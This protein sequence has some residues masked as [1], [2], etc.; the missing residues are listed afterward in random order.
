V[1]HRAPAAAQASFELAARSSPMKGQVECGDGWGAR[2][3]GQRQLLC[4][5]DGLGHGPLAALA[6]RRAIEAFSSAQQEEAPA[7]IVQR[8]HEALKGT[9]G[10]VMAVL[11]ID[12]QQR[13]AVFCGI[14][15]ISAAVYQRSGE[16]HQHLL[17][18]E[19][20]VGYRMRAVRDE[21]IAWEAGTT[22]I[23]H[24]DGLSARWNLARYPG[25]LQRHPA[26]IASVLFRDHGRDTDDATVLVARGN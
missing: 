23:L 25:L 8:A 17:S 9:R 14:G 3:I 16:P 12:P 26:L 21:A 4:V 18:V 1:S 13:S 7:T 6:A 11:A 15:N 2:T 19:G 22:A 5:V 20:I 24:T 10:A